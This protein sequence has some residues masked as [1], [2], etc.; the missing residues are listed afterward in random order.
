MSHCP[1]KILIIIPARLGSRRL[2]GKALADIGGK[3]MLVHVAHAAAQAGLGTPL[4]AAADAAIVEAMQAHGIK[5]VLTDM[6]LPSGSDRVL[7]AAA[8]V[9]PQRQNT[10]IVNVQ[11]DMPELEPGHVHAAVA[12]LQADEVADMATLAFASKD[13]AG[14]RDASV[15]KVIMEERPGPGPARA[16]DFTRSE[17]GPPFWHH[18]GIYAW[19]RAA[20]ERFCALPPSQRERAEKLE[21]LRALQAGMKILCAPVRSDCPGIDT[22]ADLARIRAQWPRGTTP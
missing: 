5:A 10:I 8:L 11:G 6:D 22:P 9:D 1:A 21:Q 19:R 18:I 4:V 13:A 7:A 17:A 14:A 12:A 20:L 15:V 16:L 3:P 2:P